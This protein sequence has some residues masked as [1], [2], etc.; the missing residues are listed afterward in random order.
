MMIEAPHSEFRSR[1]AEDLQVY[2]N[3]ALLLRQDFA[4]RESLSLCSKGP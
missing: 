3:M 2:I 1:M 4:L